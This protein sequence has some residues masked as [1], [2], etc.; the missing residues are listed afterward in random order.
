MLKK[1]TTTN[2]FWAVAMVIVFGGVGTSI[3]FG[4]VPW[5]ESDISSFSGLG[6]F[7]QLLVDRLGNVLAGLAI[8]LLGTVVAI[9]CLF[10]GE[11]S[12]D[13]GVD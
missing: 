9:A 3:M 7:A 11:G 12:T 6:K 2:Q 5:T 4:Y 10:G 13:I 1:M 8:W